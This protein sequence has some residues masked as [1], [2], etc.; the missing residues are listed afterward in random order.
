MGARSLTFFIPV[1]NEEQIIDQNLQA[2][3]SA[4][5]KVAE[6]FEIL[7]IDDG[8]RDG[9]NL[10]IR[11]WCKKYNKIR[12]I[13]HKI[14]LGYGAALRSGFSNAQKE[15]IFY[16]DMDLPADLAQLSQVLPLMESY[17]LLIGYRI[18]RQDTLRRFIY[19]R[20]N[21]LLL[22]MLFKLKVKDI[23]FSFK[24]IT[25]SALK[26]I[27]LTASTGFIDGELLIEALRNGCSIKELPVVYQKRKNGISNFD[28]LKVALAT[29]SEV[30]FYWWRKF[31]P[32][33][34]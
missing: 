11:Q 24:C 13:E 2:V 20:L 28:G 22:R 15:L 14:N 19:Y 3:V 33:R 18:N 21:K 10:K 17:D 25:R 16:T 5:E 30:L 12:L 34:E 27:N 31:K 23:N 9:S 8:S 6:D 32:L 1:F 26:K 4:V 29:A 7:I